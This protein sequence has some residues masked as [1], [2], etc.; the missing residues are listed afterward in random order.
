MHSLVA[1]R[2]R[3]FRRNFNG[4]WD[5]N[6]GSAVMGRAAHRFLRWSI[7]LVI[8]L[9]S[10]GWIGSPIAL[11]LAGDVDLPVTDASYII[12]VRGKSASTQRQGG[13]LVYQFTEGCRLSQGLMKVKSDRATLWVE[14]N[15]AVDEEGQPLPQKMI[16]SFDGNVEVDLASGQRLHDEHW[17]QRFFSNQPPQ[18][19]ADEWS[20]ASTELAG[21]W[22]PNE[23]GYGAESLQL[24]E[25]SPV[26]MRT[27]AQ[28]SQGLRRQNDSQVQLA[29][30]SSGS[31]SPGPIAGFQQPSGTIEID[32]LA[33]LGI[34]Q[35]GV[36]GQT[37]FAEVLPAPNE[38]SNGIPSSGLE[39]TPDGQFVQP[40]LSN[41]YT[42]PGR[43]NENALSQNSLTPGYQPEQIR[44]QIPIPVNP[45][46]GTPGSGLS[47]RSVRITGRTSRD[48]DIR[49]LPSGPN[50]TIATIS[51][52]VR[53]EI[54]GVTAVASNGRVTEIGK[55]SIDADRAVL[56]TS[57]LNA[58]RENGIE[59][60]P[61]E[62]YLEG[63]IYFRQGQREIYANRMY[64]D[65]SSEYGMVLNAEMLTPVP[66]YEGLLRLKADIV[67]QRSRESYLAYNAALTSSRLGVPRY[68]LQSG[69]LELND[70]RSQAIDANTGLSVPIA[71]PGQTGMEATARNNFVYLAGLPV[72]YWP[73]M[74]TNADRPSFYLTG[75]KVRNDDIFGNQVFANWDLYQLLG[76][77]GPDGTEWTLST[78][79][80]SER[81]PALG[82]NFNYDVDRFLL[83]GPTAGLIDFWGIQDGGQDILGSDR[84]LL[85]P[86]EELRFRFLGRHR[87]IL[88][89]QLEVFAEGGWVSDR[90]FLEQYFE[91]EWDQEKDYANSLRL[92]RYNGNRMLDFWG[93]AR[94]N[95]FFTE[96]EWLPKIDHYWLGQDLLERFTWY[97]HTDIGYAHQRVASTPLDA[98]DA[99]KFALQPWE[100]DAEGL[101]VATR[102][103]LNMPIN[104]GISKIV[105]YLSGEVAYWGEDRSNN[106][107]TRLTGQ[108]GIRSATSMWTVY[109]EVQSR[110][111]NL[112]GMAHKVTFQNETFYADSSQNASDLPLYDPI[113]DNSQEHFRRRLVFNTFGGVLPAQFDAS[114][115]A[116][117]Q[118]L[119]R[120]VTATSTELVEDQLQSRVGVNQRWQTK[121]GRPGAERITDVIELDT[122]LIF[123]LDPDRDNFGEELGA[124]NYD[125]R[126]HIGDRFAILSD[127]YF[128]LFSQGLKAVTLGGLI[129][130]PG[131]GEWYFGAT[132][133]EGPISSLVLSS[134]IN[135]R[136]NEK[137]IATGGT[138][139]DLGDAGNIGQNFSVT[140]IG[141]SFL[142]RLGV[143]VDNGRDNVSFQFGIEPRF[144]PIRRLGTVGGQLI[145]PAGLYGLE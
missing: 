8:V 64:Y 99:G 16:A 53:V 23:L 139:V 48:A 117:R 29:Q 105:P 26:E 115:Y 104:L 100:V 50:Q 37:G 66:Q 41:S 59:N 45:A 28:T 42:V 14:T 15:Q 47:A 85:N 61:L 90:N 56:W 30:F 74:A 123:F 118:G 137:W 1:A 33:P 106:P 88:S 60:E 82:S 92:R 38:R 32:P 71:N 132:S 77:D 62:L 79:Y 13:Y 101:R 112:N 65:A 113:D 94:V 20:E 128:D 124:L 95:D 10:C 87:Q 11:V 21:P 97:A 46:G 107:L 12:S 18:I 43:D 98:Q 125:F 84:V 4:I 129:S 133:L 39:I 143:A 36:R 127:G 114:N 108:A 70:Q 126:Y 63:N 17:A 54:G 31:D 75:L 140:R 40:P 136:L 122:D 76:L 67:Q 69:Q 102:Q 96:T 119:Q 51:R 44:N 22:L 25:S 9:A 110:L 58:I 81:G 134:T 89:E 116:I 78:D 52:G 72:F 24:S 111:L 49:F 34:Q 5:A 145:P 2:S 19:Q 141:E 83:P 120:F 142:A 93:Q 7:Q 57:S 109:P 35:P 73:V 6:K 68:W 135:Y 80:L 103:E 86:E 138:A 91:R 121:R 144:L 131:R 3:R 27:A 55:V 130:R